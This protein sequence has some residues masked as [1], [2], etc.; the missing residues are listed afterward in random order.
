[1]SY[2]PEIEV[3]S[4]PCPHCGNLFGFDF[5]FRMLE[6]PR[7]V[8]PT[9]SNEILPESVPAVVERQPTNRDSGIRSPK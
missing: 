1:M 9:T 3:V 4:V 6:E 2:K 5:G 7:P 8:Y